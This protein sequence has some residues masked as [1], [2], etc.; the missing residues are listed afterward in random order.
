[1]AL[2]LAQMALEKL[3]NLRPTKFYMLNIFGFYNCPKKSIPG[4]VLAL[5]L[6]LAVYV[7]GLGPDGPGP[8]ATEMKI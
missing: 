6:L 1:M 7:S 4:G 5:L 8:G 3:K 2:D